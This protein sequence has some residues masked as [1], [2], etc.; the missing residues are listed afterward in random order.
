M[1][2]TTRQK[3]GWATCAASTMLALAMTTMADAGPCDPPPVGNPIACENAN[4]GNPPSEWDIVDYDLAPPYSV[5]P[6]VN[7]VGFATKMSVNKGQSIDFKIQT[8]ATSFRI[9]VYRIGYYGGNGARFMA[10]LG[11]FSGPTNQPSPSDLPPLDP[12][13][14]CVRDLATYLLDC[15]NWDTTTSWSVPSNAVSGVYIAKLVRLSPADGRSNHIIFVVRDDSSTS[16]LLVQT[17][18]PTWQA[19]NYWGGFSLYRGKWNTTDCSAKDTV[20]DSLPTVIG[21]PGRA[22]KVSYN[23]PFAMTKWPAPCELQGEG[24]NGYFRDGTSA[25]GGAHGF[26]SAEYSMVR[27]LERNGFDV[28]YI[29]GVDTAQNGALLLNHAT[30]I[31]S[32]HDEYWSGDQRAAVEKARGAGVNLAFFTGND[33]YIKTRWESSIAGTPT[34]Y[35]TLV[36]Y[37]E[38]PINRQHVPIGTVVWT[39]EWRAT[40]VDPPLDGGRPEN[41]LTGTIGYVVD[42]RPM[43]APDLRFR[44]HRFWRN[45]SW[46]GNPP[47]PLGADSNG[48]GR[49]IGYEW[50]VAPDDASTPAGLMR[51]SETHCHVPAQPEHACYT[52]KIHNMTLYRDRSGAFVFSAATVQWALG[53]EDAA[54]FLNA[55]DV[56]KEQVATTHDQRMQQATMNLLID[57]EGVPAT[58]MGTLT[59]SSPSSDT[60]A[61]TATFTSPQTE[62]ALGATV[63]LSGTANDTS[64][65]VGAVELSFDGGNSWRR[66]VLN[67]GA[68]TTWTYSW[69]ANVAGLITIKARAVD[70]SGNIGASVSRDVVVT[71]RQCPCSIWDNTTPTSYGEAKSKFPP[72]SPVG[73]I[74]LGVRFIADA[75]GVVNGIY[76]YRDVDTGDGLHT[77]RL[78]DATT[79]AQLGGPQ[80]ATIADNTPSG[81]QLGLFGTPIAI[82][83]RI[84]YIASYHSSN[85]YIS[86]PHYFDLSGVD[87]APLHA[88]RIGNG[89]YTGPTGFPGTVSATANNYW[90]DLSF[91][92]TTCMMP[93]LEFGLKALWGFDDGTGATAEN[94]QSGWGHIAILSGTTRVPGRLGTAREF[95]GVDDTMTVANTTSGLNI[96]S[97]PISIGAWLRPS[98]GTNFAFGYAAYNAAH[99]LYSL[100]TTDG[101][102]HYGFYG[103]GAHQEYRCNTQ[104]PLNVFSHVVFSYTMG[105]GS[106]MACYVNGQPVS[107]S[108]IAGDGNSLPATPTPGNYEFEI[109]HWYGT[110][111]NGNHRYWF[112]GAI[113]EPF[114]YS[115]DL[116]P[117]EILGIYTNSGR[118]AHV[119]G[120]PDAAVGTA[121]GK[122]NFNETSTSPG[123]VDDSSGRGNN[124]T[125][126]NVDIVDGAYGLA[127]RFAGTVASKV[128]LASSTDFNISS[129]PITIGAWVMPERETNFVMGY[130]THNSNWGLYSM[131][132]SDGMPQYGFYGGGVHQEYRCNAILPS[133]RLSMVTFT[134]TMGQGNSMVCYVDGE[135]VG[136]K[137]IVGDGNA[138]PTPDPSQA[139]EIGHWY[140]TTNS[141]N[142]RYS[143]KGVIDEPFVIKA[144]LSAADIKD[145]FLQT[146]R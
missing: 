103:G 8:D 88:P 93:V 127:R 40:P 144:A 1:R 12:T 108:W 60:T 24:E 43:T 90:V 146:C 44:D 87:N 74:E 62:A 114:V 115:R 53:I 15:G 140:G 128:T 139:F 65:V 77:G 36:T 123:T 96:Q 81:W 54:P 23:R 129:G 2:I 10:T 82:G 76:Y 17:S 112:Q 73:D 14:H 111:A 29:S 21:V 34:S 63:P 137:W 16:P 126:A 89:V 26:F 25:T 70:D 48:N 55:A 58:P 38:D 37:K 72:D 42:E 78:W 98:R 136:G 125:A 145:V 141:S 69:N 94:D 119:V 101:Y 52:P 95:D 92:Y 28:S 64:G 57:L 130:A 61:P 71:Q 131:F 116:K 135:R 22:Y 49:V 7:L 122:W 18:D 9:D 4:A 100:I 91:S 45:I 19:Y 3:R 106:T 105:S 138:G 84:P 102:P 124:G 51:L 99:G 104:L 39:G 68:S 113:D 107:G 35:R 30:F 97:G 31:A 56:P 50:N 6:D 47:T 13:T 11:T 134:Y 143:F 83:P 79:T 110:P 27:F 121:R 132:I 32:G 67:M 41:A 59:V 75:P 20:F 46:S 66:A 109:G 133:N 33:I 117:A 5:R 86:T 118:V 80:T 85:G 120:L 142:D